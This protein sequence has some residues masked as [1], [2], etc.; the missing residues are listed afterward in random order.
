EPL[1]DIGECNSIDS[2][3]EA[4]DVLELNEVEDDEE[5]P[6]DPI[7]VEELTPPSLSL[8]VSPQEELTLQPANEN[9]RGASL[10][11]VRNAVP[12]GAREQPAP[13]IRIH[14]SWDRPDAAEFFQRVAADPRLSRAEIQIGRGGL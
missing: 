14:F 3:P 8:A 5:P 10:G 1:E 7:D 13:A 9:G 4:Q 12:E 11:P 2:Q 6:F